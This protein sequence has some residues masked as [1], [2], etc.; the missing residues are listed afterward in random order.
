MWL[1][2]HSTNRLSHA[3]VAQTFLNL[4][5]PEALNALD[6]TVNIFCMVNFVNV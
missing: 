5:V 6:R 2:C 3:H 4:D 1:A